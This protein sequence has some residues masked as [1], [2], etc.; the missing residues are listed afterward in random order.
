[1]Y[2][3]SPYSNLTVLTLM[4]KVSTQVQGC[5][6]SGSIPGQEAGFNTEKPEES[7]Q[8]PP[9]EKK[10][11]DFKADSLLYKLYGSRLQSVEAVRLSVEGGID[12]VLLP[13]PGKIFRPV[14]PK[15]IGSLL[16]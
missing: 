15:K 8:C 10:T 1:M 14:E 4:R 16:E 12:G 13:D 7:S 5:R 3:Y 9:A 6:D 2:L 11:P